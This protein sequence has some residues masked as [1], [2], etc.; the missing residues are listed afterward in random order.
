MADYASIDY[1]VDSKSL[2][3]YSSYQPIAQKKIDVVFQPDLSSGYYSV[4]SMNNNGENDIGY[5]LSNDESSD[6]SNENNDISGND[7]EKSEKPIYLFGSNPVNGIFIGSVTVLGL[8][9]LYRLL[10]K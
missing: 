10:K 4:L 6:S 2:G 3:I 5:H 1:K 8:F 9:L 7:E